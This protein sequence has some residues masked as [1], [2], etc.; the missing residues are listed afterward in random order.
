MLALLF[1]PEVSILQRKQPSNY[2]APAGFQKLESGI[3]PYSEAV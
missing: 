1:L 2:S 3:Y